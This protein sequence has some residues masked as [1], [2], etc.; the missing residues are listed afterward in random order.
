MSPAL[1][2]S[3][4]LHEPTVLSLLS[5]LSALL[6]V[7]AI[8]PAGRA[9]C[10]TFTLSSPQGQAAFGMSLDLDGDTL[11]VGAPGALT[12]PPF[13][14]A[15]YAIRRWNGATWVTQHD[16]IGVA[17][18]TEKLGWDV[19]I[20]GDLAAI[21]AP[22]LAQGNPGAGAV[23]V[24]KRTG[25]VWGPAMTGAT[26]F[27]PDPQFDG[28]FGTSV[29]LE[30]DRLVV[31]EPGANGGAGR[32]WLFLRT[33]VSWVLETELVC[34]DV[35]PGSEYGR[36]VDL[37][38]GSPRDAVIVGMPGHPTGG[39]AD[40][41]GAATFVRGPF[42]WFV[43]NVLGDSLRRRQGESVAID[44]DRALF[45]APA[46]FPPDEGG[47][48]VSVLW[49]GLFYQE[50]GAL[51]GAGFG[52]LGASVSIDGDLALVGAPL[53]DPLAP[54]GQG[55]QT[56]RALLMRAGSGA[57]DF[58]DV[59][60]FY[61]VDDLQDGEQF[62]GAVAVSGG[63]GALSSPRFDGGSG[64]VREY[65]L[66]ID[67]WLQADLGGGAHAEPLLVVETSLCGGEAVAVHLVAGVPNTTAFL[68]CGFAAVNLPFG[69][70]TLVPDLTP[71]GFFFALPV[72]ATGAL[73]LHDSWPTGA[74]AGFDIYLQW[75]QLDPG[76]PSGYSG[77]DALR[78]TT[79]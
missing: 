38:R 9:Q 42:G 5:W 79:P 12:L 57:F 44:G 3:R 61:P 46:S 71:P 49:N 31:G 32:A 64:S 22:G 26:L 18:A 70:G 37:H 48:V 58:S 56:G 68:C 17:S 59:Q 34:P 77:S 53:S 4:G 72:G 41:G 39:V 60:L 10:E 63:R 36:S 23:I 55:S 29:A 13:P 35:V 76:S 15:G 43:D 75:W 28:A 20:S 8:A 1:T 21:G 45:G 24:L 66:D 74:P 78:L 30:G 14:P 7:L 73:S 67:A 54:D 19:A 2:T 6:L 62:G 25:S 11:I 52:H 40:S 50:V 27:P 65:D 69:G 33:P 47:V 16:Q 51:L